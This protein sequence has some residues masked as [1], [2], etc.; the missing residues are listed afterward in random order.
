M[1]YVLGYMYADG[2]II[3]YPT[4]RGHYLQIA[5]T[6]I[7]TIRSLMGSE[8][9]VY[10]R[11]RGENRKKQHILS[12]GSSALFNAL[13]QLSVT[14]NKSL[15]MT[16]PNIPK[17]HFSA[18]VLGYFDGDGGVYIERG[19][20]GNPKKL[21]SVFTSGSKQFLIDLE[22]QIH[23][24][25]GMIHRGIQRHCS[26]KNAYQLRYSTRDSLRLFQLMYGC[27]SLSELALK[28]KYAI[29]TKYFIEKGLDPDNLD[30]IL[31]TKGPV[32]K[33]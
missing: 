18:F 31:R 20:S 15:T 14:P 1:A 25:T 7:D 10:V 12:I 11:N 22:C 32:V 21:L 13:T 6:D 30:P 17:A 8:H 33:G 28:R 5:S 24:R 9:T 16:L 23:A 19:T 3:S 27:S 4:I 2:N 29:F 26:S